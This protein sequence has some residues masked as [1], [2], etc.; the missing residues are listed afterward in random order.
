MRQWK[1]STI[2]GK[3]VIDNKRERQSRP[4]I[5]KVKST[6]NGKDKFDNKW[7]RYISDHKTWRTEEENINPVLRLSAGVGQENGEKKHIIYM[8]DCRLPIYGSLYDQ[9]TFSYL[10]CNA[11]IFV[12]LHTTNYKHLLLKRV[13]Y[14][15]YDVIQFCRVNI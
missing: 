11:Y 14:T 1:Q 4:Q 10:Q 3:D 8:T 12:S 9:L 6:T 2:N 7:D 5:G 13:I 15:N